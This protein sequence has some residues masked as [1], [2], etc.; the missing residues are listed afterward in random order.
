[1]VLVLIRHVMTSVKWRQALRHACCVCILTLHEDSSSWEK[2]TACFCLKRLNMQENK[3]CCCTKQNAAHQYCNCNIIRGW[4][5]M[6]SRRKHLGITF[7]DIFV[8]LPVFLNKLCQEQK[9][10]ILNINIWYQCFNT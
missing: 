2:C 9:Y 5:V 1:M 7:A 4:S 6:V 8:F 10:N 3:N